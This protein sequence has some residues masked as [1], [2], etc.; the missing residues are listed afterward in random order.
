[1][2]YLLQHIIKMHFIPNGYGF[3]TVRGRFSSRQNFTVSFRKAAFLYLRLIS[4]FN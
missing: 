1:M 2:E 4:S 3:R